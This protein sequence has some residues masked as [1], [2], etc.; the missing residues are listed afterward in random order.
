M[1]APPERPPLSGLHRLDIGARIARLRDAGYLTADAA[2]TLELGGYTLTAPAADRMIENVIGVFGLPFAVVGNVNVNGRDYLVPMSVEE[3]SIVAAA[4]AAAALARRAGGFTV[5]HGRAL[6]IGQIELRA[7]R[8]AAAAAAAIAAERDALLAAANAVHPN[9]LARGGGAVDLSVRTTP[10]PDRLVVHLSVDTCDAMGANLVNTQCEAVAPRIAGLAGARA[11]LKILSNFA[12]DALVTASVTLPVSILAR[13]ETDG[14]AVRDGI[15]AADRFAATDVYRAVTHNK[16]I[17]NGIDPIAIATGND[18]RAIEA[19]AHAYAARSGIY[20]G[21]SNWRTA[22]GGALEGTLTLPLKPGIVGATIRANPG[23]RLALE[24]AGVDSAAELAAVMAAVGLAQNFAALRALATDGIQKGHMRLHARSVTAAA[25]VPRELADTVVAEMIAAGEIKSWKAREIHARLTGP[26]GA[27]ATADE[28]AAARGVAAGKVIVGGEHAAVYGYRALAVPVPDAVHASIRDDRDA[29][30]VRLR[31]EDWGIERVVTAGASDDPADA[32]LS[33]LLTELGLEHARLTLDIATAYP[34]GA[35]L[36]GSASLA[37]AIIRALDSRFDLGLG[38]TEVNALAF[39]AERINHGD[40]SGIDNTVAT[41]ARPL[42][43]RRSEPPE[44]ETLVAGAALPLVVAVAP[45][46][47]S[48]AA[49]VARVAALRER[50]PAIVER[51]FSAIDAIVGDMRSA[52]LDGSVSRLG[53]LANLNHGLLTALGVSTPELDRLCAIARSAGASGAK[54]T[55]G[56]GGGAI[57]AV[58]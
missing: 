38:D 26:G 4:S 51:L 58:C 6:L 28:T 18:W 40:A 42:L 55:G 10:D 34:L 50:E 36:G 14:A 47:Q 5:T 41:Y 20:R 33:L 29:P 25:G 43:F 15:V 11:G 21:L 30:G 16:G 31:I 49:M 27:A 22:A 35:G 44:V 45:V 19:A 7:V 37:V 32:S 39:R 9:M 56:G 48:T 52:L 17:M 12:T 1:T 57:L 13:G 46:R 54:L 24:L 53:E 2:A 23:A 8:D 3:P